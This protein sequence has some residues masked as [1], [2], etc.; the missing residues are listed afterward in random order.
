MA[1]LQRR[2]RENVEGDFYV[3]DTCIDCDTCRW[4]APDVFD[5]KGEMSRV[6]TQPSDREGRAKSFQA[7]LSCPTTSIGTTEKT[8]AL[9]E[10]TSTLPLPI[11]G[12]VHHCGFHSEA[13]FGATPYLVLRER[14]NLLIDSPRFAGPLVKTIE[15]LGGVSTLFLT[16]RDD[17]ADHGK[18]AEHF[19]ATRILHADDVVPGTEDVEQKVT[20][21]DP[22]SLDDE[23]LLLPTPG[24]TRG[25]MCLL[26][27]DRYLFTG[28]HLA[29]SDRLQQLYAF[30]RHCFHDWTVQQGAIEKLKQY[31][32]EWVL[33]GHGR[34]QHIPAAKMPG[35]L[36]QCLQWMG[37][38]S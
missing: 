28:D 38:E 35:A 15:K 31:S 22:V 33:P 7:L 17:V 21:E 3:D 19:S 23:V 24:H 14:G 16:H 34:R 36:D 27:Q 4:M 37:T 18:W 13:S 32:F 9:K 6:H 20:G 8:N 1:D 26:F 11:E 25:S 29:W 10:I 2:R 5:R 30:R 12:P